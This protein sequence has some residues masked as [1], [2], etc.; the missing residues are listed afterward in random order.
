M[1]VGTTSGTVR[2]MPWSSFSFPI[3]TK[4][5]LVDIFLVDTAHG[6]RCDLEAGRRVLTR[7]GRR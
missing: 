4:F 5:G 7:E 2:F 1:W 6:A 3:R